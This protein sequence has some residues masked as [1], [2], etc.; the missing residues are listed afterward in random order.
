MAPVIIDNLHK[1]GLEFQV[2]IVA[3]ILTDK[4]FL[5]RICDIIDV[6]A[7]E[8]EAH[9]WILKEI[10]QYHIQYKDLPTPQVFKVRIDT[11]END[12]FKSSVVQQLTQVYTKISEKDCGMMIH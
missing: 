1:F 11:I 12:A 10:I 7:F 6:D 4:V 3:S 5:E 9:Q 2:K 8:N